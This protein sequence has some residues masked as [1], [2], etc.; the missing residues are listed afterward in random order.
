MLIWIKLQHS[1]R[2]L[3]FVSRLD[4]QS[5]PTCIQFMNPSSTFL[6]KII[7]FAYLNTTLTFIS[8]LDQQSNPTSVKFMNP[9]ST[10]VSKFITFAH[11]NQTLTF[12]SIFE[13]RIQIG[14]KIK[15]NLYPIHES[16]LNIRIQDYNFC[17]F[18]SNLNIRIIPYKP[19]NICKHSYSS[20]LQKQAVRP[21]GKLS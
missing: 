9:S 21:H 5:N 6:S 14:S 20:A 7:T 13:I 11:L 1:Y 16:I 17:S 8:N 15:S 19:S 4:Q 10:F 2:S 12:V 18:E 3:T